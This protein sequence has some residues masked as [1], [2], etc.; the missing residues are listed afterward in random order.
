MGRINYSDAIKRE[1][2]AH[3]L[4]GRSLRS[5]STMAVMPSHNTLIAW[6]QAGEGTNGTPWATLQ[7][8]SQAKPSAVEDG[9]VAE[10]QE[11]AVYVLMAGPFVKVGMTKRSVNQRIQQ[12][13]TG[14]PYLITAYFCQLCEDPSRLERAFHAQFAA[15]RRSGEW[16]EMDFSD[17]VQGVLML[18]ASLDSPGSP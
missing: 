15:Q 4:A 5:I 10:I 2:A 7:R 13:Q 9:F 14:C 18:A 3:W 1:A 17:A 8:K 6:A 11:R 12:V 16:F